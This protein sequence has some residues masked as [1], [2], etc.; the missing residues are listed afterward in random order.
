MIHGTRLR[1]LLFTLTGLVLLVPV[2]IIVAGPGGS[3]NKASALARFEL[4]GGKAVLKA[5]KQDLPEKH[6][7]MGWVKDMTLAWEHPPEKRPQLLRLRQQGAPGP[8]DPETG[9][10][11]GNPHQQHAHVP[12]TKADPDAPLILEIRWWDGEQEQR[13]LRTGPL[14]ISR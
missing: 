2:Y 14:W 7:G 8:S 5:R 1:R 4:G 12:V 11:H 3:G 10:L 13:R 9:L 6:P